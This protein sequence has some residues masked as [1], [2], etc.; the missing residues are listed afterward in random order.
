MIIFCVFRFDLRQ[1]YRSFGGRGGAVI[2]VGTGPMRGV[3]KLLI[4]PE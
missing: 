3:K 4:F 2:L 1:A